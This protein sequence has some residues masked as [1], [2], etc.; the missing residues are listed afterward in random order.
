M[1]P[2]MLC[3][4]MLRCLDVYPCNKLAWKVSVLGSSEYLA[5][6]IGHLGVAGL[7]HYCQETACSVCDC[8]SASNM[9]ALSTE[10]PSLDWMTVHLCDA[11]NGTR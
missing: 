7:P 11:V 5:C 8:D 10:A 6:H 1:S 4:R 2:K 9:T 3:I